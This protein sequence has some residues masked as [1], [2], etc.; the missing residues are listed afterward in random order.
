MLEQSYFVEFWRQVFMDLIMLLLQDSGEQQSH[1]LL[2]FIEHI[3]FVESS[4]TAK[5]LFAMGIPEP[6]SF[7]IL[8]NRP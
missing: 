6:C 1:T 2:D 5:A 7:S 4:N 8:C 3:K